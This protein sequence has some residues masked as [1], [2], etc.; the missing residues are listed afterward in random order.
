MVESVGK[1]SD[2][3]VT[4]FRP[5]VAPKET[6]KIGLQEAANGTH[7]DTEDFVVNCKN[8]SGSGLTAGFLQAAAEASNFGSRIMG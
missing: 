7:T 4:Q 6:L 1:A 2:F 8:R 5:S 3:W